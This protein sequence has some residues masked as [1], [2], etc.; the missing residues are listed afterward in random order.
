MACP[1][2]E[3]LG[4]G[5]GRAEVRLG[6]LR[7]APAEEGRAQR[8]L[9]PRLVTFA[10]E[11]RCQLERSLAVQNGGVDA[12]AD[13][14]GVAQQLEAAE[15]LIPK[16]MSLGERERLLAE[17]ECAV[18]TSPGQVQDAEAA[19]RRRGVL[20]VVDAAEEIAGCPVG[21][22]GLVEVPGRLEHVGQVQP[23]GRLGQAQPRALRAVAT[24]LER[25]SRLVVLALGHVDHTEI[26]SRGGD[27]RPVAGLLERGQAPGDRRPPPRAGVLRPDGGWR[28]CRGSS[29]DPRRSQPRA[30]APSGSARSPER[31]GP[32][33]VAPSPGC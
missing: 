27:A 25:R 13:A 20:R 19:Q 22:L 26:D 32:C 30:R 28:C 6:L 31:R 7:L 2:P 18:G 24:A 9:D 3:A 21:A 8:A 15:D 1:L 23:R 11:L 12:V 17:D 29:L 14:L 33:P 5:E 16:L 10:L 4:R